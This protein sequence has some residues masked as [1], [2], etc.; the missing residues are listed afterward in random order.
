[1]SPESC[2]PPQK[3]KLPLAEV[4]RTEGYKDMGTAYAETMTPH[5]VDACLRQGLPAEFVPM[6]EA[7]L[8]DLHFVLFDEKEVEDRVSPQPRM[9]AP[10]LPKNGD[11]NGG[12]YIR[13]ILVSKQEIV[14][15]ADLLEEVF[16]EIGLDNL[17]RDKAR[18]VAEDWTFYDMAM[19]ALGNSCYMQQNHPRY[20]PDF[21]GQA[22]HVNAH[23]T[24][25]SNFL[26]LH[27]EYSISAQEDTRR[28]IKGFGIMMVQD[29]LLAKGLVKRDAHANWMVQGIRN[30]IPDAYNSVQVS[31]RLETTLPSKDTNRRFAELAMATYDPD[32]KLDEVDVTDL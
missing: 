32:I 7:H 6:F 23:R 22:A 17:N 10:K 26:S 8:K 19:V 18:Q 24:L 11:E 2:A 5:I 30:R 31:E 13:R 21:N 4:H 20:I 1:M 15:R 12:S 16:G 25:S 14:R 3:P 29:A 28:L 9:D 27:P